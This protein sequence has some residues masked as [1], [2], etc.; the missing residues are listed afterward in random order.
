MKPGEI[1]AIVGGYHNDPFS[2]L[3]L[4]QDAAADTWEV[5]V[6]L[7][8]AESVEVACE[9]GCFRAERLHVDGF[10][11]ATLPHFVPAYNLL[12][13]LKHGGTVPMEDPYRFPPLL[14][15]FD[16]HLHAEGT[17]YESFN[18]LGAHFVE[19][20]GVRGV[21][22]AVWAP[23]AELVCL[24][25][26]FNDWDVRRHPMRKREGGVWE[27]FIPGVA[28]GCA[29]KY[30][31]KS[32]SMGGRQLKSDPYG[33]AAEVPP[34]QASLV[35]SIDGYEWGD[36]AWMDQRGKRNWLEEPIS[37]Y[38]V[39]LASWMRGPDQR[40]L[41]YRELAS[42]LVAYVKMMGF[43]HIELMPV[44]E[45]PYAGS[46][47]YQVVGFYAPTARFGTPQD[48]MYFVDHC[49]QNGIG[50]IVDWVPAHYPRDAHGLAWFDGS[51]LYEHE[52]PRKG[53]HTEW[54]TLIFN[55]GR[56]EVK[57][58]LISN[59]MFWLKKYHIDGLRVDAVASM[60]Y[61]D[62]ARKAGEWVPNKYGGRENLEA[63]E[64]L[65]KVNEQAH[66]VPGAMTL[67]EESTDF[68]GV[69]HPV[70]ANGLGFTM[71]WNMGWMHDMFA[72][73]KSDPIYRK[74][75]HNHITFSLWYAFNENYLLPISHDEVVHGKSALIGK[76]PGDEWQ[77]FANARAFLA[78]MWGHPGKKLL[79]M[80]CEIGQ[81]EEW[82]FKGSIRWE[83]LQ[84][85]Y[86]RQLQQLVAELNRLYRAHPALYEV[87][88]KHAG[89][90][91][92]DIHDVDSSVISFLRRGKDPTRFLI[93][94]CNFTPIV[95]HQYRVGVPTGGVYV[96]VLNTDWD[97]FGGSG[98]VNAGDLLAEPV[99][100]H[101][102]T[103]SINLTLPPLAVA[104]YELT[105]REPIVEG[106]GGG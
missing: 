14:T 93:Y 73:F 17:H 89:F 80:G 50:V 32:R 3:G 95:R 92:I 94:V 68:P 96:E 90:E 76:M 49:H 18:T 39:H 70:Y 6:F 69:S 77:R 2:I 99:P 85:D 88:F 103:H 23:E 45:H 60:L 101:G 31:V 20:E 98:V 48:F 67:A 12:L 13:H 81:Y 9:A 79:F 91:W 4:H 29:Y 57:T 97:Q 105:N 19:C 106:W 25:G 64:F 54:G 41:T 83:L 102:R 74:F 36:N 84:Y 44:M 75:N 66:T 78:Y 52:D 5:R 100:T 82:N 34:K 21:R 1:E 24:A 55:Y 53:A 8:Q 72:Y 16:L 104:V 15:G 37:V 86:H 27:I 40:P 58:F 22:F 56:N 35:W 10:F 33:F 7:P 26:D 11:R 71:K 62:Y 63:I 30:F 87:D 38:E 51:A 61:L 59:A 42:K 28:Q 65:R 46:W 47:G 43:T